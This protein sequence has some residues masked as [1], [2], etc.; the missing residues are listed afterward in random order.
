MIATEQIQIEQVPIA[1]LKPDPANPRRISD[2]EQEALTRSLREY[3]FVQPVIAL[4]ADNTVVGG[5]QRLLAARK[6]G[7][8]Q[9]PVVYVDLP[10]EQAR[11]LNLALNKISG[12]WDDDLLARMVADLSSL[13]E[14]DMSL[15]GF[16]EDELAKL[17]KSLDH[18]EKREREEA[19]DL[20]AALEAAQDAH[21]AERGDL[22]ALGD[23]A[24]LLAS[25]AALQIENGTGQSAE[26]RHVRAV[27]GP[28][29]GSRTIRTPLAELP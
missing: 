8:K 18:R 16:G 2:A 17:M 6:L 21:G 1:Q 10:L 19:F 24:A 4:R 11:L 5:H 20:D 13:E 28:R 23:H 22:F 14:I 15:S 29:R 25:I 27:D 12:S 9:V 26:R 7:M 3:G